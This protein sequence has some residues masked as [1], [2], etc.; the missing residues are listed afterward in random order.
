[1][2]GVRRDRTFWRMLGGADQAGLAAQARQQVFTD[3]TTLCV[4]GEPSTHVFVL[5]SGWVKVSS[6]T[7]D[8]R[9]MLLAVRGA[10]EVLGEVAGE[11]TGY[12]TATVRAA[13]RVTTL[14]IG[15]DRF[16]VFLDSHP[17]AA[18]AYRHAMAERHRATDEAQR[19]RAMTS[20]SHRLARLLLDVADLHVDDTGAG[21]GTVPLSQ[22]ELASLIG[23]SRATVTRAL[24]E[25][26][27]R[28]IVRTLQQRRVTVV[29]RAAL[30]RIAGNP[31]R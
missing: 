27:S 3:G 5:T 26:R 18:R 25:W 19:S 21:P 7:S 9:D 31:R 23:A 17:A 6:V 20:G 22:D 28:G 12:R 8:G 14:I 4:E 13:G 10:G 29:D 24:S 15:S 11:V 2:N 1:M 16:E 30:E